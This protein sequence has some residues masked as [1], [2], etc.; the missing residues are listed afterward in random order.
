M[1]DAAFWF[2]KAL[3]LHVRA[4]GSAL[5]SVDEA[6]GMNGYIFLN[7]QGEEGGDG[8]QPDTTARTNTQASTPHVKQRSSNNKQPPPVST[9]FALSKHPWENP[10]THLCSA[11]ILC[12]DS[13]RSIIFKSVCLLSWYFYHKMT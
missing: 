12:V 6:L 7:G 8:A 2:V 10:L 4:E 3:R 13:S 11:M 1:E 5:T 9:V